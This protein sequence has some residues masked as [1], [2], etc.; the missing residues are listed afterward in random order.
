M[1]KL[2]LFLLT[3]LKNNYI[4]IVTKSKWKALP[5]NNPVNLLFKCILCKENFL[6]MEWDKIINNLILFF[7]YIKN[8][9]CLVVVFL[10]FSQKGNQAGQE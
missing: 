9:K 3:K 7:R 1:D 10:I 8:L 6:H 5:S 2:M 4:S